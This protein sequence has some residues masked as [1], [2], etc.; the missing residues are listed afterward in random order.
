[1]DGSIPD[2]LDR[3]E[4]PFA[5]HYFALPAGRMHYADEGTGDPVVM[6]HGTPEWS[7]AY[8]NLIRCLSERY[9]CIAPDHLGFGLSDKPSGWSYLPADHASNLETLIGQLDLRDI[10]LIVHDYGGPIGVSYAVR[11]PENVKRL[12]IMNSWMWSL[13]GDPAYERTRLFAGA[14]GRFAYERLAFS[15][16]VMMPL[17]M[18]DRSKL[19]RQVHR[20]YL[21]ALPTSQA[22]HGT[23][24]LARELLG[25]SEWYDQ[26]WQ[27]RSRIER[28]PALI[29]WGMRDFA[30]KQKELHRWQ[31]VFPNARVETYRD[32]GHFLQEELGER[33]CAPIED[34]MA[35]T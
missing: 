16:R 7:F 23:W 35:E 11:K 10:T 29:L 9:R 33:L 4:Y 20:Q 30:F 32:A 27:Q 2:W 28:L 12:V 15:P 1:M 22:R 18:G 13:Q 31:E 3:V 26:L 14:F 6:V 8:R 21:Q 24:V 25:S 5:P 17:A 19:T 34:F